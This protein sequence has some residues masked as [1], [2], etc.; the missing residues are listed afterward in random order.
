MKDEAI[1]A[2]DKIKF[3]S[4]PIATISSLSLLFIAVYLNQPQTIILAAGLAGATMGFLPLI[5]LV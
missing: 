2:A 5:T 4:L 1:D 3:A